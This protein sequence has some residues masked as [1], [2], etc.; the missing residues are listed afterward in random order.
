MNAEP[1]V[2][3]IT[4]YHIKVN[5]S[6]IDKNLNTRVGFY[7]KLLINKLY[8]AERLSHFRNALFFAL[9]HYGNGKGLTLQKCLRYNFK[10]CI[11]KNVA[12]IAICN[13]K[14]K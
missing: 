7:I 14:Q 5:H 4:I 12:N 8:F 1:C 10:I 9:W 11:T 13:N 2:E 3:N 6:Y